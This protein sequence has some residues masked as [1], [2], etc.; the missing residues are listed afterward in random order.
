[1]TSTVYLDNASTTRPLPQ[2]IEVMQRCL[3]EAYGNSA[4]THRQGRL[5]SRHLE[6][7][8]QV[9]A[10]RLG[11][12][13]DEIVFT[14]GGT[15]ANN[16]AI[17]GALP[18]GPPRHVITSAI[19]HPSVLDACAWLE[20]LGH[21][22]TRLPVDGHGRVDPAD[23]RRALGP[24]TALVSIM[25]GNNEVGT[26][27]PVAELGRVCREAGVL[28][29]TDACQSFTRASLDVRRDC[30]D[31]V[32]V[33]GHKIHGPKGAGAL[34]VRQGVRLEPL[35]HGGGQEL[36][37]RSGTSNVPA[38]AGLAVAIEAAGPEVIA[39]LEG[40][41]DA[42]LEGL[43]DRL[44]GV[45]ALGHP[46]ERLAGVASFAL[47]GVSGLELQ[48]ALDRRGLMASAGSA[49]HSGQVEPSHVIRALGLDP[50]LAGGTL[51][52]SVGQ[53]TTPEEVAFAL[54]AIED[55]VR[56]LRAEGPGL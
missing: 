53:E 46:T 39:R 50:R 55:A 27:Q 12:D 10:D 51:R 21:R 32:S 45:V 24:E 19:E 5:A 41:R 44:E 23:L 16:L 4:S 17:K 13:P 42:L 29:H 7:A 11:A 49:C 40:L 3:Q 38:L 54:E 8:R 1:M 37:R 18:P 30:L 26:L 14:S 2:V 9:V 36:G 31:L 25:H 47:E 52:L 34:F 22:V 35:L 28:F 43:V 56:E 6:R 33:N 15:E 20:G 48:K